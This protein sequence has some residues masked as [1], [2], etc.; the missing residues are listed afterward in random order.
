M[1]KLTIVQVSESVFTVQGHGVHTAFVETVRGLRRYIDCNV[2]ENTLKKAD[3]RHIHTVGMYSVVQL[4]FCR[5]TKIV[6]A[7]V[8]P[9][10]FVGSLVGTRY[11][12]GVARW[13]LRWFYNRA[14]AVIAVSDET[15]SELIKMG[16]TRPIHVVYNM[17]DTSYYHVDENER[18]KAR[19][20]LGVAE[21][22][23]VVVSNGQVQPRKRVDIFVET[24]HTLPDVRFF[25][26]GGMSFG[27]AAANY[28]KMQEYID[29]APSN[30]TFTGVIPLEDVQKYL[31]AGDIFMMPSDQ[32]TFGLAIVEAAASGLPVVLRDIHDYN[33]T[34][35]GDAVI[36]DEAGFS[37]AIQHLV[38]DRAFYKKMRSHANRLA[39]RFDSKT[40]VAQLLDIYRGQAD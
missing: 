15:K 12:L 11:W 18:K 10:S 31:A 26:V 5:G 32:E 28:Q 23:A 27:R 17:I 33:H 20:A 40:I 1:T 8:I 13:Y 37:D 22:A 24:A 3:I 21:G 2:Y 36:C 4:L 7:H 16:V 19:K 25:W 34:F 39:A 9:E 38:D 14:D 30:V 6:S 29:T 35:R